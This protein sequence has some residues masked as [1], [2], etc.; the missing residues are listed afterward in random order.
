MTVAERLRDKL[1]RHAPESP[2]ARANPRDDYIR[3]AAGRVTQRLAA[4]N[5][6][7]TAPDGAVD[8]PG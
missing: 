7:D 1:P 2:N 8:H 3:A 4:L 6:H 5:R